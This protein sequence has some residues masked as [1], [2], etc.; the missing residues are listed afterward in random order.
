M[1]APAPMAGGGSSSSRTATARPRPRRWAAILS[2]AAR[3]AAPRSEI[4]AIAGADAP[5]CR[6]SAAPRPA[7]SNAPQMSCA[8]RAR[9]R[10]DTE[11]LLI[12]VVD[13]LL[14]Q[15]DHA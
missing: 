14:L 1:R 2:S 8:Q 4:S 9:L 12:L 15:F 13:R 3:P 5:A 11:E 6:G 7:A 10:N